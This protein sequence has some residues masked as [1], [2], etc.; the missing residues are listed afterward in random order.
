M[1]V[2]HNNQL[3]AIL[4]DV[5]TLD[6]VSQYLDNLN[7]EIPIGEIRLE[8]SDEEAEIARKS[9]YQLESD[10]LYMEWQFDQTDEAKQRWLAKVA[11]IKTRYPFPSL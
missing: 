8:Y 10:P 7:I 3:V 2:L 6:Q 5:L 1:K 4:G 9:A 11:E